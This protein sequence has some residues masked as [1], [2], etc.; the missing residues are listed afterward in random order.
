MEIQFI[1]YIYTY[2]YIYIYTHI[3]VLIYMYSYIY[4]YIYILIER[5]RS[6]CGGQYICSPTSVGL[7]SQAK[8][9]KVLP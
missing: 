6:V 9:V 2:I 4:I 5:N 7:S 3:Y 1:I 8:E